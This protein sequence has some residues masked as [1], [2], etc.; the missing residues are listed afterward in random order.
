MLAHDLQ[1]DVEQWQSNLE[2]PSLTNPDTIK[3]GK[4]NGAVD[5]SPYERKSIIYKE[6]QTPGEFTRSAPIPYKPTL[7]LR[8]L[9]QGK[10]Y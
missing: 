5:N 3:G 6:V 2:A 10:G 8:V 4:K 1:I 7:K 9:S